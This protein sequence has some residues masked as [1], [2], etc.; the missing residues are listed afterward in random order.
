MRRIALSLVALIVFGGAAPVRSA[1]DDH[2]G[3][4]A[5]LADVRAAVAEIVGIEN[6]YRVGH[7]A[8][9]KAPRPTCSRLRRACRPRSARRRWKIIRP[10]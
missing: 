9:P 1:R 5:A 6:G 7:A 2:A 3:A 10:T 4:L 8:Y